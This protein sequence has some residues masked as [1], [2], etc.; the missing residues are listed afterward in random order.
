MDPMVQPSKMTGPIT[1]I[2]QGAVA[3]VV[4]C[5]V[6]AGGPMV[7]GPGCTLIDVQFTVGTLE[8]R[9]TVAAE[10]VRIWAVGHTQCTVVTWLSSTAFKLHRLTCIT[11]IFCNLALGPWSTWV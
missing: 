8:T 2:A 10:A 11:T 6:V 5:Q 3:L 1:S 7:A 9:H 4:I